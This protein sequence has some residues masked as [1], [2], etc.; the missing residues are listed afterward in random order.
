[1][2]SE[3]KTRIEQ[4]WE[5]N[6][7]EDLYLP[8]KPKRKTKASMAREKGLEP[9]VTVLEAQRRSLDAESRLLDVHRQRLDTRVN[10]HLALGGGFEIE[11]IGSGTSGMDR[12]DKDRKEE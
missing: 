3:L 10:L 8:Y 7:L 5:S 11:M 4:T 12:A 1:M 9:F 2:T 6:E